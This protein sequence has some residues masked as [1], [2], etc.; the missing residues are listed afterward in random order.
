MMAMAYQ[1]DEQIAAVLTHVRSNFG[2]SAPAVTAAEVAALRSEV[3][4]PQLTAAELI[5]PELPA[6]A[7][8]PAGAKGSK[9]DNMKSSP[10]APLWAFA[11]VFLFVLVCFVGVFRK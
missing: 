2:N 7:E 1:S 4:K 8:K 6:A 5:Q 9:Y 3:G 10:G 11:A